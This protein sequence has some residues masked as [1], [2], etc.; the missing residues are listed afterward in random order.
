MRIVVDIDATLLYSMYRNENYIY[1]S[2]NKKL[3]KKLRKMKRRG[4][5]IILETGRHWD[6]LE[7]TRKQLK[8]ARVKYDTLI[9]GK[10]PADYY[11]DDKAIKPEDFCK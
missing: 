2:R 3:I 1:K 5:E 9:M 4:Y 10:P 8:K 11:I 7:L 6:H